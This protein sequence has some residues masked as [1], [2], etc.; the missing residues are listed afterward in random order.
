MLIYLCLGMLV[1]DW[2]TLGELLKKESVEV[3]SLPEDA[4]HREIDE[5]PE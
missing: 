1:G 3:A 2:P 4:Q 5:H